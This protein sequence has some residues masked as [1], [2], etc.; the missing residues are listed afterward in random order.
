MLPR[1]PNMSDTAGRTNTIVEVPEI[2]NTV[3]KSV[4]S[5]YQRK[6]FWGGIGFGPRNRCRKVVDVLV[7]LVVNV[8]CTL[9]PASTTPSLTLL[10]PL[11]LLLP[12]LTQRR[13]KVLPPLVHARLRCRLA[14]SKKE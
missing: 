1:N 6:V 4:I 8:G 14:L 9:S 2:A 11:A 3:H 5:M 12:L 10:V 13:W 7:V